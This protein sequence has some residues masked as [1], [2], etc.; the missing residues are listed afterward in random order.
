VRFPG[1]IQSWAQSR[2]PAQNVQEAAATLH[3]VDTGNLGVE[4]AVQMVQQTGKPVHLTYGDGVA[5]FLPDP[6]PDV[7][8][9]IAAQVKP[10]PG[11]TQATKT[12][13]AEEIFES[14][15]RAR[16]T[17]QRASVFPSARCQDRQHGQC[18]DR[19]CSCQCHSVRVDTD[20]ARHASRPSDDIML[21]G[22]FRRM[23]ADKAGWAHMSEGLLIMDS[24]TSLTESEMAALKR[25]G[26]EESD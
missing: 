5:T 19:A 8:A 2:T 4:L 24:G 10:N 9:A 14:I 22:V 21:A 23:L 1:W 20:G 18:I 3:A 15:Q 16:D 6:D 17:M 7:A 13:S 11:Q 25:A 26:V 12:V